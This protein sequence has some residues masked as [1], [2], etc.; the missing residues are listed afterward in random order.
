M[1]SFKDY[2]LTLNK[3]KLNEKIFGKPD[4]MALKIAKLQIAV[5]LEKQFNKKVDLIRQ[6]NSLLS[7]E[8]KIDGSI[9]DGYLNIWK[10]DEKMLVVSLSIRGEKLQKS[11]HHFSTPDNI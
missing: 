11:G 1:L 2:C 7:S 10:N 6:L 8:Y 5:A 3:E 4:K 9:E